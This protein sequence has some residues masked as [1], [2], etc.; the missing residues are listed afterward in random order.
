MPRKSSEQ[1][2]AEL[3]RKPAD[4]PPPPKD[5]ARSARDLWRALIASKPASHWTQEARLALRERC[6]AEIQLREVQAALVTDP[7]DDKLTRMRSSL[8]ASINV[9]TRRLRM[10]PQQEISP[11]K[12]A[13]TRPA[14][15]DDPLI[16]GAALRAQRMKA[17]GERRPP[18][19]DDPLIGGRARPR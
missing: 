12:T 10:G 17:N 14:A 19:W 6:L 16:G 8:C 15:V 9:L 11:W 13:E 1:T 4:L 2:A 7:L 5:F 3:Y 18:V